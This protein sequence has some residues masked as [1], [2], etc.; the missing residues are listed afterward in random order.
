MLKEFWVETQVNAE[1][2]AEQL[3]GERSE[4]LIEFIL[5][6]DSYV[7]ETSFTLE[8]IERL[9]AVLKEEGTYVNG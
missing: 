8:L 5:L 3:A 4:D 1:I 2:L 6:L 7:A 9:Q